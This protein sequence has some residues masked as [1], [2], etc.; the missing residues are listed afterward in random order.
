MRGGKGSTHELVEDTSPGLPLDVIEL[1]YAC[2]GN[3]AIKHA[4]T[5]GQRLPNPILQ[6]GQEAPVKLLS[7]LDC[8]ILYPVNFLTPN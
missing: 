5:G 7:L 3:H 2:A 4:G 1:T 6:L 8:A